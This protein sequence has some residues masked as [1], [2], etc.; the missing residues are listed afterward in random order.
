[1]L[2]GTR[3]WVGP[4]LR[5]VVLPEVLHDRLPVGE[6][7]RR[8]G[9]KAAIAVDGLQYVALAPWRRSKSCFLRACYETDPALSPACI[10]GV[11]RRARRASWCCA[12]GDSCRCSHP[13]ALRSSGTATRDLRPRGVFPVARTEIGPRGHR[14]GGDPLPP[15]SRAA[16]TCAARRSFLTARRGHTSPRR[17]RKSPASSR[18]REPRLP[19]VG[20]TARRARVNVPST[21][22][23]GRTSSTISQRGVAAGMGETITAYARS[24]PRRTA[25]VSP[26]QACRTCVGP[27][28]RPVRASY[29][30]ADFRR[31]NGLWRDGKAVVRRQLLRDPQRDTIARLQARGIIATERHSCQPPLRNPLPPRR[32]GAEG[33]G[34]G[35]GER[36]GRYLPASIFRNASTEALYSS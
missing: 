19:R 20:P 34:R 6:R 1:M 16:T 24:D 27:G 31:K 30:N 12:T 23:R 4:D 18:A 9:D 3:R 32:R 22:E 17:R 15:R 11:V 36:A 33:V 35:A 5:L 25:R 8:L 29:A 14:V 2:D 28:V 26:R 21:G 13:R 7:H 10:S